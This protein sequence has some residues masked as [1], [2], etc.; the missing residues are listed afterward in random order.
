MTR[1]GVA[2]RIRVEPDLEVVGEVG[3]AKS[4]L[5]S[6]G[7]LKP[8]LVVI[9]LSLGGRSGLDVI[10]ELHHSLPQIPLLVFSMHYETLYAERALRAGARGY[11]MKGDGGTKLIEAIRQVLRGE[12]Y[13]SEI[14]REKT[15]PRATRGAPGA[16]K[17]SR[18]VI[19]SDREL[20]VFEL[21]GQGFGPA[22][23]GEKLRLSPATVETHRAHIRKKLRLRTAADLARTAAEWR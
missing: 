21:L 12:V 11:L 14:M 6:A 19:L 22:E 5:A 18:L 2:V 17:R 20:E 9:D 4:A 10:R 1:H 16:V 3:C 23:I 13:L 15:L 8:D 7:S